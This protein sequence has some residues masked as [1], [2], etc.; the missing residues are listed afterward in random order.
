MITLTAEQA[1]E[2]I[3]FEGKNPVKQFVRAVERGELPPPV[4]HSKPRRWSQVQLENH[5]T[6]DNVSAHDPLME[7]INGIHKNEIR[8]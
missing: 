5:F 2:L 3:G 6:N 7:R 8:S 4:I 1:A